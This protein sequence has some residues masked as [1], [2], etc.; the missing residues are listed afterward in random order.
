METAPGVTAAA[1]VASQP[2]APPGTNNYTPNFGN[3]YSQQSTY[4]NY[5][6]P[7]YN[8]PPPPQPPQQQQQ[9]QHYYPANTAQSSTPFTQP[10]YPQS[11]SF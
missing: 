9:Y 2:M 10:S 5:N 8:Q 3:Y 7:V 6:Q 11:K 1:P 4:S